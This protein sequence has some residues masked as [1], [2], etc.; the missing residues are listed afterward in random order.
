MLLIA[1]SN[2]TGVV[3]MPVERLAARAGLTVDETVKG[4]AILSAPDKESRSDEEGGRRLVPIREDSA[5][6]WKLVN[7]DKYKE[8]IRAE[9]DRNTTRARVA[10]FRDKKKAVTISNDDVT[11]AHGMSCDGLHL[12]GGCGGAPTVTDFETAWSR[13][14]RKRGK[15]DA[16]RHFEAQIK[17]RLSLAALDSAIT[18]YIEECRI[19]ETGDKYMK[20]GSTFFN[21]DWKDF[22]DGTWK[23]P[24]ASVSRDGN[25][26]RPDPPSK[27]RTAAEFGQ[28]S[29]TWR[30]LDVPDDSG[31]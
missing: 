23:P 6:G 9:Q 10:A 15:A 7:Y 27:M 20:H 31:K 14:P 2:R 24:A 4:L 11:K 8:I 17:T 5:R 19:L 13:Y 26:S 22:V 1:D 18:N 3:D 30:A 28:K 12:R 25:G 29:E 16:L 21:G